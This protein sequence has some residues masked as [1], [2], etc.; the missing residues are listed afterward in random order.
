MYL[1]YYFIIILL[2]CI[3]VTGISCSFQEGYVVTNNN[4]TIKGNFNLAIQQPS[5]FTIYNTEKGKTHFNINYI[6]YINIIDN[7]KRNTTTYIFNNGFWQQLA[8]KGDLGIYKIEY[9][10]DAGYSDIDGNEVYTDYEDIA[11]FSGNI[12]KAAIYGNYVP[13]DYLNKKIATQSIYSG[14]LF[15]FIKVPILSGFTEGL[16][17]FINTRYD[18][19]LTPEEF[20]TYI[21]QTKAADRQTKLFNFILDL[22][23]DLENNTKK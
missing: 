18:L 6:K 2:L 16:F 17:Q 5:T 20:F 3:C 13:D 12:Q 7:K 23:S 19:D 11:L 1:K 8:A 9:E 10:T 15:K 14:T 22:E 21:D 4:D